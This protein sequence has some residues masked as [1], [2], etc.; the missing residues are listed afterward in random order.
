MG[1][2]TKLLVLDDERIMEIASSP[3][4]HMV[5]EPLFDINIYDGKEQ[6]EK[7]L[8]P[9]T[10]PQRHIYA[11]NWYVTEVDNGGHFQFYSNS[12]GIVWEDALKGFKAIGAELNY[13]ILKKSA[14]LLGGNPSKDRE[15]RQ[16]QME[17]LKYNCDTF[18]ELDNAYFESKKT[19]YEFLCAYIKSNAKD[20]YYSGEV[21]IV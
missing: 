17:L 20:F 4:P 8:A 2:T 9:F 6:Y 13:D 7:D 3:Y 18:D 19:M 21:S 15:E 5:V 10:L 1:N 16:K 11:I 12:T 14:I